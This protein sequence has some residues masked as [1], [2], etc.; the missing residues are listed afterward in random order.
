[1]FVSMLRADEPP[2]VRCSIKRGHS[3]Q[4]V[5]TPSHLCST[6]AAA[7]TIPLSKMSPRL[8]E[9]LT[10]AFT[11]D[12]RGGLQQDDERQQVALTSRAADAESKSARRR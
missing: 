5:T 9:G 3:A 10:C 12:A 2:W 1:M 11:R 4:V 7:G 8:V 6:H